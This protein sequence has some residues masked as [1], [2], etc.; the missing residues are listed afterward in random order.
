[1]Y[2][3]KYMYNERKTVATFSQIQVAHSHH[4]HLKNTSKN[5]SVCGGVCD[6]TTVQKDTLFF[7]QL[8]P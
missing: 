1:M 5:R 8:S 2:A 7:L 3:C 4:V 6:I